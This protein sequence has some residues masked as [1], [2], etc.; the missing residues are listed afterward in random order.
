MGTNNQS[1]PDFGKLRGEL[2]QSL[3]QNRSSSY[4]ALEVFWP[5]LVAFL[6]FFLPFDV[7]NTGRLT[8]AALLAILG[9]VD[10]LTRTRLPAAWDNFALLLVRLTI[11]CGLAATAPVVWHAAVVISGT[12]IVGSIPAESRLR[13][14]FMLSATS[15]ALTVVALWAVIPDWYLSITILVVGTLAVELWYRIWAA[16]RTEV[17]R[18]HGEILDRARLFSWEI[19][20]KTGTIV[21][22][23]GNVEPILGFKANELIGQSALNFVEEEPSD[24]IWDPAEVRGEVGHRTVRANHR[25]GHSVVLREVRL[26]AKGHI[27]RGISIDITELA[28]ATDALRHQAEHDSLTGLANREL[29]MRS[30]T[31]ALEANPNE[32]IALILA[33]LDR[34]KE[35]NDTLGHPVGDRLLCALADCF[36]AK[37]HDADMIA[38]IG[39]DEFAFVLKGAHAEKRALL[40]AEQIHMMVAAPIKVDGLKLG[41]ACS[42]GVACAPQHGTNYADLLKHS[43]IAMYRA[44]QA[45]GGVLLFDSVPN[46]L[47]LQRLQLLSEIAEAI[48]RREFEL[49]MQPKVDLKT[50]RIVGVEGLARWRHPEFGLL[51]PGSFFHAVEV[52]SDYHRFTSEIIRQ[53]VDFAA[54][55]AAAG[56]DLNVAV[57]L[58]SMSFLDQNLPVRLRE[59]LSDRRLPGHAL[60]VEVT[61]SDL[62]DAEAPI[63]DALAALGLRLSIDDF[64]TGYSSLTR[65]RAIAVDEVKIDRAFVAGLGV[66]AED[67]IIVRAVMELCRLLGHSVVAEGVE[68]VEQMQMLQRFGCAIGQGYLFAKAM[69]QHEMLET[70]NSGLHYDVGARLEIAHG[71]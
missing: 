27:V 35:I 47:S 17:D 66:A 65:L 12:I 29:L 53:A 24:R 41:V 11:V 59:M 62:I 48:D 28:G 45:G 71:P 13:S 54:S 22:V 26:E 43:D 67:E 52:A 4:A 18:R 70:L 31:T 49:H 40:L 37:L 32:E 39:G 20:S 33:D 10:Y 61:E 34:F 44:K 50:G 55:A 3:R 57:N 51:L 21:G 16:E 36:R 9:P 56:H 1:Y 38:R 5:L 58:G 64:G 6:W 8:G 15:V 2:A 60:T 46:V 30:V 63:F 23:A 7:S 19:D 69:P 25:D 68:T 42:V 14:L